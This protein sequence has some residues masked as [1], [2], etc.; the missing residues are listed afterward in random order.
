MGIFRWISSVFFSVLAFSALLLSNTAKDY[1]SIIDRIKPVGNVY[2][3][4]KNKLA[5]QKEVVSKI[6]DASSIYNTFCIA[7]HASGVSGAPR[8]GNVNDWA[9][10]IAQGKQIMQ[11]N[12][13]K[14]LNAMPEK[15][16]CM[17]CSDDELLQVIEYMI[18]DL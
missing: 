17:D 6:R 7:C 15:G 2:I 10:R 13:I 9:S 4:V 16:L 1:E 18:K 3:E 11:D 12:V 5:E 14:G 8:F